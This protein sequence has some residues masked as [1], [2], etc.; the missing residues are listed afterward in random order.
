MTAPRCIAI[1]VA[2]SLVA[3]GGAAKQR[4]SW[5]DA[6]VQLRDEG[7]RLA[8]IDRLWVMP[9]G[10]ARD[11]ARGAIAA[12]IVRRI[13]DA[14]VDERALEAAR[15]FEQLTSLWQHDPEAIGAGLAPHVGIL[16]QLRALFAKSGTLDPALRALV[17]LAEVDRPQRQA[18]LAE[19]GELLAYADELAIAENGALALR[20]EPIAV[21]RPTAES[22]P[23]RWLVDRYVGLLLERQRAVAGIMEKQGATLEL[24]RAHRDVLVTARRVA[25]VLARAGRADDI[26]TYLARI[27]GLGIDRELRI[28]AEIVAQHP[29][30]D[31]Y[32]ELA[33]ELADHDETADAAAALGITA[34]GLVRFPDDASLLTLAGGYARTL[35]RIDQAIVFYERALRTGEVDAALALRLGKLYAERIERLADHGRPRAANAA[36]RGVVAFT[37]NVARERPH[38]VWQQTTAIAESALGKGL[39][40]QGLIDDG[41]TALTGSLERAPSIDA[42]ETLATVEYQTDRLAEAQR[43]AASGMAMLGDFMTADRYHRA[44]L[45][46]IS[47]DALRRAGKPREAAARYLDAL[48]TWASLGDTKDLPRAIA[49]ERMMD[50]GRAMWWLGDAAKSVDLVMAAIEHSPDSPAISDAVAFLIEV[51]R[52]RDA[53]DA[54][55]RGLG[56][57]ELAEVFKVYISLWIVAEG[58]RLA[59]PR[60]RLAL[61]YLASRRGEL[62]YEQLARAATG[63]LSY[64]ALRRAAI[65]GPQQG[66]LAFYG[67]VL[68]LAPGAATSDGRK[69]LLEQAIAARAIFDAEYDL[70][71]RYLAAP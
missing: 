64:A 70:A 66:E 43:W 44:K 69:R 40:G 50:M 68:G 6:P 21:M 49:G 56:E 28:R 32:N 39:A 53:V 2:V 22:L 38:P 11:E 59:E 36:W 48:R 7:D 3:C 45:E 71:R 17:V 14:L 8:A 13:N 10:A 19:L 30:P 18:Q 9:A 41:R 46:R 25:N 52:Y 67:A 29:T 34:A 20:G 16:R 63:R 12:A 33:R 15:L 31:A 54:C 42:Y 5:P 51:G 57:H 1:V 37:T 4:A 62:W 60:D 35:G 47:A 23:L 27:D 55:H 58:K 24:V 65:T 61:D 26:Q